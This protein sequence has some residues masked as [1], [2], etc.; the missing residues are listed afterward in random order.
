MKKFVLFTVM[1]FFM[2]LVGAQSKLSPF[3][4][5][6]LQN[7]AEN[8]AVLKHSPADLSVNRSSGFAKTIR[9]DG[10][11]TI[12]TFITVNDDSDID[13]IKSLGAVINARVG[14]IIMA[15][16]PVDKLV[17]VAQLAS[18]VSVNVARPMSINNDSARSATNTNLV[19]NI[20]TGTGLTKAYKGAG[21]V[22]GVVDIGIDYNN[23][24]FKDANGVSR[25]KRVYQPGDTTGT[26]PVI[27]GVALHGSEYTTPEQIAA[28]TT[29][30][31]IQTH[32]THTTGTA[33]GSYMGNAFYGM[34]P[35]AD[36]VLCGCA[37]DLSDY[38]I[39]M[40]VKYIFNYAESVGKPA[41]V[42]LSI[43]GHDGAH[44]GTSDLTKAINQMTGKGKIISIS[45]GNEGSEKLHI[46]KKFTASDSILQSLVIYNNNKGAIY[47]EDYQ[48]FWTRNTDYKT[49]PA[50]QFIVLNTEND[51]ILF[52]SKKFTESGTLDPA[53]DSEF[54]KYYKKKLEVTMGKSA[55]GKFQI[56][57]KFNKQIARDP[58]Y[59]I[60]IR[61]ICD[62]LTSAD[63]W[64]LVH[65]LSFSN[66]GF[67][68]YTDGNSELS[69]NDMATGDNT[70]SVG[71][72]NSRLDYTNLY[73]TKFSIDANL[74]DIADFSSYG[75][76]VNGI[77]R[78]EV[79]APGQ[80]LISP[81]NSCYP[82]IPSTCIC[83]SL[84]VGTKT[85]YWGNMSGTSMAA[86]TVTG[87]IA[88]W[89]QA[90]P[91]LTPADIKNVLKNSCKTDF[92]VTS[93]PNK[94]GYG[95]IDALAGL[96]YILSTTGIKGVRNDNAKPVLL[97]PNPSDGNFT[98][99]TPSESGN[100]NMSIYNVAGALV[101]SRA[102]D[103]S[104]GA[105]DVNLNGAV[106]PGI[107]VLHL[108]GAITNYS[109]RL[110]LK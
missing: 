91:N 107:Y 16:V 60:G 27:D 103:G 98:V 104:S 23:P 61:Y 65:K 52:V 82:N 5:L 31:S 10:V 37:E 99:C 74:G 102:F 3:T 48:A 73:G 62:S 1:A 51:S 88:L 13:A 75:P 20:T 56:A 11:E 38:N 29:D 7:H 25:V 59:C 93:Y 71:A 22:V 28:L 49:P 110:V 89:L 81:L 2:L 41:V 79:L 67:P 84:A 9:I 35:E 54:N 92:Y 106:A 87:I 43:G 85:Y 76:D 15:Q 8:A 95:K 45:A 17:D 40:S 63:V 18:V 47:A 53:T 34:A 39:A 21:V 72:Y 90:N 105:V 80:T 77:A 6:F 78:P 69:I 83:D 14:D 64:D 58:F 50:L 96:K 55:N 68:E 12:G 4:Q 42:N 100:V 19:Q 97:Y 101:Y 66:F 32:G 57:T 86:P 94:S 33:A 109:S 44:D 46:Y 24:A 30:D 70:I 36:L 26:S 108:N